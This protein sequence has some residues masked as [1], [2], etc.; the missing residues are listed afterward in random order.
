ML[1]RSEKFKYHL[2]EKVASWFEEGKKAGV[3]VHDAEY[4]ADLIAR[5]YLLV[6]GDAIAEF[7]SEGNLIPS[8]ND[9]INGYVSA[10]SNAATQKSRKTEVRAIFEA[11]ALGDTE[12]TLEIGEKDSDEKDA[13]GKPK[14]KVKIEETHTVRDW[15]FMHQQVKGYE[16][17]S[18]L[19][20]MAR[21]FRGPAK[22]RGAGGGANRGPRAVTALQMK[23]IEARV[24]V[25]DHG[26]AQSIVQRGLAQLSKLPSFEI[27]QFRAVVLACDQ[28]LNKSQDEAC[29]KRAQAIRDMA[30]DMVNRLRD[31]MVEAAKKQPSPV[32][33]KGPTPAEVQAAIERAA[34]KPTEAPKAEG[35]AT[36]PAPAEQKA[37]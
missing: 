32:T 18:G 29:K 36:A 30:E 34:P 8:C 9:W 31:A 7:D 14:G 25:M 12:R 10:W 33:A 11:F 26:Q 35:E 19:A 4:A 20:D 5:E 15:L 2:P 13:A 28:I 3:K 17:L 22:G 27:V 21:M 23:D 24:E 16:R 6:V 1:E 37:A